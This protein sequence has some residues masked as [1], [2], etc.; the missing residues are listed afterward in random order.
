[1]SGLGDRLASE[2]TT[3]AL[4]WRVARRDGVTLGFT[5]HDREIDLE[6]L[7][8]EPVPGMVPSAISANDRLDVDTME[9]GGALDAASI[10]AGDLAAGRYDDAAVAVFMLDWT[11]PQ[12]GRV[13]LARGTLG[14]VERRFGAAGGEFT[15]ELRSTTAVLDATIVETCSPECRAELG[16]RRC[17]VDLE[18]LTLRARI[19]SDPRRDT[20]ALVGIGDLDR[21]VNGRLR[22]LEGKN[23]GIDVRVAA[24]DGGRL[25]LFEAFPHAL[26][27]FSRVELR[28][29]CDK[30]L[31]SCIA[32]F[33][34]GI[35]FRGEPHVPGVDLLTR[36]SGT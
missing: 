9:I 18:P 16:D 21:F 26:P 11:A 2:A 1:M 23:A 25:V 10:T 20:V 27:P 3:L 34:N 33:D 36:F 6:G 24:V 31:A 28:E 29:G 13:Q 7:R 22:A 5:T 17:R 12:A 19:G 30:R 14:Q 4:C 35:N 32:R 15:A 8:Y